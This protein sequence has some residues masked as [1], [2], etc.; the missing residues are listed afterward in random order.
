MTSSKPTRRNTTEY[1]AGKLGNDSDIGTVP[2]HF[3][4]AVKSEQMPLWEAM[5]QPLGSASRT[6]LM[7]LVARLR[8]ALAESDRE[9]VARFI[10]KVER[11]AETFGGS[12]YAAMK[13]VQKEMLA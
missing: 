4:G 1:R 5:S 10:E 11:K 13:Q 3:C 6:K 2:R 12:Y 9:A 7:A 8:M